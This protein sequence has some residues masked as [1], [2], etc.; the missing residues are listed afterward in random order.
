MRIT[1]VCLFSNTDRCAYVASSVASLFKHHWTSWAPAARRCLRGVAPAFYAPSGKLRRF[2]WRSCPWFRGR[3]NKWRWWRQT[4]ARQ[5]AQ[6]RTS[7]AE[8]D[9]TKEEKSQREGKNLSVCLVSIRMTWTD[10]SS[11][12]SNPHLN[13]REG[14]AYDKVAGPIAE[15]GEG[16]GCGPRPLAEQ[17][18][19]DEPRDGTRTN[20][21]EADEEEDGRHADVAHPRKFSLQGFDRL[22]ETVRQNFFKNNIIL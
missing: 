19:H 18:G 4:A 20:L 14:Q 6:T 7:R 16:H 3:G 17:L 5:T 11:S 9:K 22:R 8:P 10:C 21:E 2:L 12:G 15:A 1:L 13:V